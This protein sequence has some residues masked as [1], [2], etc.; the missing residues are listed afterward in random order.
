ME[1]KVVVVGDNTDGDKIE[2]LLAYTMGKL[3]DY[4]PT[5]F[6]NFNTKTVIDG[7]EVEYSLWDTSGQECSVK[8]RGLSYP[9]TDVFVMLFCISNP[10]SL[11]N[12]AE[13]WT[14]EVQRHCPGAK[15]ILVG[16]RGESRSNPE[17]A[18]KGQRIVSKEEVEAV[19]IRIGAKKY[20]ETSVKEMTGVKLAIQT[21]VLV[22]VNP[23]AFLYSPITSKIKQDKEQEEEGLFWE[24]KRKRRGI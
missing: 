11:E 10:E 15:L 21:A 2:L 3:P 23:E 5:V 1:V 12:I 7:K 4:V 22:V 24:K 13:I 18:A 17:L 16:S 6:D 19:R 8:I 9:K 14:P 20:I